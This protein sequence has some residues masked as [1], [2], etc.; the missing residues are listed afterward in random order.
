MLD[1]LT[2]SRSLHGFFIWK[3]ESDPVAHDPAGYLPKEKPAEG[4]IREY[5]QRSQ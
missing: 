4:V 2:R 3:Y 1:A 5:L